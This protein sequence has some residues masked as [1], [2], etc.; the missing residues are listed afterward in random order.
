MNLFE[1]NAEIESALMNC[2]DEETGEIG[3]TTQLDALQIEFDSKVENL[4]LW[5]KNM[6]ADIQALS[7]EEKALSERRKSKERKV[8]RITE[9]VLN[10]LNGQKFETPKCAVSWRNSESV[11]IIDIDRIPASY[12]NYG[13]PKPMKAEIKKAIKSGIDVPG[14]VI[15][16]KLNGNIK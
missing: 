7:L 9:Y 10:A 16:K 14:A 8:A 11:E 12:I 6:K 15:E 4:C 2:I 13:E 5:I 3:D 1:L